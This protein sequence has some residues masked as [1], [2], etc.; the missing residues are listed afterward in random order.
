M[1]KKHISLLKTTT[2]CLFHKILFASNKFS[3][4]KNLT[5]G[6]IVFQM[7]LNN[8]KGLNSENITHLSLNLSHAKVI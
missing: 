2:D 7:I 1:I 5:S 6:Q 3:N 8:Y 4:P